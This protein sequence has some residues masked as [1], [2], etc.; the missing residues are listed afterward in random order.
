MKED[1]AIKQSRVAE[2]VRRKEAHREMRH[3]VGCGHEAGEDERDRA[4]EQAEH[5]QRAVDDGIES[6]NT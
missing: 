5:D 3:E 4:R 1:E 6:R 2:V